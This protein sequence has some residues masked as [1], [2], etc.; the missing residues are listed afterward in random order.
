MQ[1]RRV[2]SGAVLASETTIG[3]LPQL[4]SWPGDGGPFVTLPQCYTEDA[5]QPGM[6]RSNLGM[7]RVQLSG[8]SYVSD[9]E[10]GLHYQI[11]RGIGVHHAAAMRAGKPLRVNI[12]VGGHPAMSLEHRRSPARRYPGR[13]RL[14]SSPC[15]VWGRLDC[16]GSGRTGWSATCTR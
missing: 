2:R 12:F 4:V 3:Q 6:A 14:R 1:P 11:H 16:R 13:Q 5:Q 15:S 8:S 9:Q 7:Y 10:I